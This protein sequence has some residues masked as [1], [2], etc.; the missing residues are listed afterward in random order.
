MPKAAELKSGMVVDIDGQPYIVKQVSA[1]NPTARGASTLYKTR[2]NH[3]STGQKLERSFKGDEMLADVDFRRRA[4]QY[5]FSDGSS[6][7]FMDAEDY[8]QY[9]L[10]PEQVE[11]IVPFLTDGG[12]GFTALIVEDQCVAVEPPSSIE[13]EIVETAPAMK[14]ASQSA[15]TKTARLSTG[16]EIQVPE[17]LAEGERV[18]VNTAT[19]EFMSRA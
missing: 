5:L 6:Y 9:Q 14:G 2:L 3:A 13:L 1:H 15:R 4:A 18:K 16:L 7:T 11:D 12:G 17:Y 19:R 8:S 10:D